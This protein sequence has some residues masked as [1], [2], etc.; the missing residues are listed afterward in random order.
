MA[1]K[2]YGVCCI[3]GK[4][5]NLTFEHIPPKAAFNCF[6]IKSYDFM[7]YIFENSTRYQSF[8]GGS[9]LYSLCASCN[10][11]T[12]EWYGA[13]YAGF[14][15]QGMTYYRAGAQGGLSVPYT[16]YPLRVLKQIVSCFASVYGPILC[17]NKP[18]I[19]EFLLDPYERDLP[20]EIDIRMYMSSN[21]VSKI[22]RYLG[23]LDTSTGELF[24]GSEWGYTP[25]CYVCTYDKPVKHAAFDTLLPIRRFADFKYDDQYTLYLNIPRKPCNPSL[26]DFREHVPTLQEIINSSKQ[27]NN[28]IL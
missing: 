28:S 5:T 1:K 27:E 25:F 3:C 15:M 4:E 20:Q 10:N 12:G 18:K 14:A 21:G 2:K 6:S 7:R 23:V 17:Q 11:L 16:I 24:S 22:I 26:L 8:Q 9:G 19:R 13:A